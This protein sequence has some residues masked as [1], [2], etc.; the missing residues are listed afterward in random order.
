MEFQTRYV[1]ILLLFLTTIMPLCQSAW[2]VD[3][4]WSGGGKSY[5]CI[6]TPTCTAPTWNGDLNF[7]KWGPNGDLIL[8]EMGTKWGPLAAEM[9]TK[10]G[11]NG[12]WQGSAQAHATSARVAH[13]RK[14]RGNAMQQ[15]SWTRTGAAMRH[16]K[17]GVKQRVGSDLMN[18][19]V[20]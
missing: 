18:G 13:S 20:S 1:H 8:S 10:W 9:G 3:F 14:L 19:C 15:L 11:L 7:S 2:L 6:N 16:R 12:T 5:F 17:I 4:N